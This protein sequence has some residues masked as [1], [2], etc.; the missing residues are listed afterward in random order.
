[1]IKLFLLQNT[2]YLY[3]YITQHTSYDDGL[4]VGADDGWLGGEQT[5]VV[6]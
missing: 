1:M 3:S 6:W 2:F 5:D 4:L